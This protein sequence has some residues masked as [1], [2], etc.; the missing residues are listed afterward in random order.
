VLKGYFNHLSLSLHLKSSKQSFFMLRK[1]LFLLVVSLLTTSA[2]LAQVTTSSISGVVKDQAGQNLAGA[3]ITAVHQPSGTRYTTITQSGG[4]FTIANMRTGGP[5]Q[6]TITYVGMRTQTLNDIYLQLGEATVING[7]LESTEGTLQNVVVTGARRNNVLNANRTGAVTNIG[8]RE[9]NRL[10][11]IS[12]SINDFT[13]ITPQANG[14]AIGGGNNRQN[15]ITVDGSDFNN[16]FGIGGNLPAGGNPISLDAVEEISVSIAPYDVRQANF[17][18]SSINTVTRSGTNQ[19][20]GSVY[21]FFRNE[22]QRGNTVKGQDF[23]LQRENYSQWG[24]RVGGPII[25]NKLF[26][27]LNYETEKRTSPGQQRFAATATTGTGSY[28][29]A[30][31]IARPTATEL[32][33]IRDY[34]LKTYNYETGPYQGY[35]FVSD[36]VKMLARI[37]WNI[38]DKHRLTARYNQ[39]EGKTPLFMSGSSGSTGFNF[40][41]GFGRTDINALHFSNS[42][43]FQEN[44]FYSGQ[45][46]LNSRFTNR[47]SNI[48]RLSLNNQFEP[49]SSNSS[50]FPFVDI[51][52]DGQPFTSFGYEPFS[53]GNLRDV[54]IFT[55]TN[56]LTFITGK[57]NFLFGAQFDLSTTR[58][59]FQPLGASYYRFNSFADFQNGALPNDFAITYSLNPDFSQAFPT[60]KFAQY[61][62]YAQDEITF[63]RKFRLTVGLRADLNTYPDVAEVKTNPLVAGLTF[64]NGA[65]INTGEL[66]K[67][68]VML[69]PRVGFNYDPNGDRSLQIRGGTGIFTG[70]VP[71]VWIVGQSGN[72]GMLQVTQSFNGTANTTGFVFNQD[73]LFHVRRLNPNGPPAAGTVIP[74]TITAFDPNFTLPQTWKSSL[75]LDRR[76]PG[77]FI[78]TIDLI[79]NRDINV[80]YSKNVNL[81][82]PSPLNVAGYPD[83]RLIYPSTDQTRYINPITAQG[84]PGAG[85][86]SQFNAIVSGNENRGFYFSTTVQLQKQFSGG[87]FASLAYT[88]SIAENLYDGNG[89]QPFNTWSLIQTVNGANTPEL[90]FADYVVPHRVVGTFSYRK[91]FLKH[92]GTMISVFYSGQ[93]QGRFSYVYGADLNRDRQT[94]DLM[95]IPRDASEI[96]FVD[97]GT[98]GAAGYVS[99]ADQSRQFFEYIEQ[100]DYLRKRKGQYAERNGAL[101]PW[102]NQFDVKFTQDLFT[103]FLGSRNTLQFSV[104]IFNFTNL[105]NSEW[106]V[107]QTTNAA[108]LLDVANATGGNAYTPGGTIRPTFRLALDRGQPVKQTFRDNLNNSS[109]YFMQFG[110]R[111]IFG[112]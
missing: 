100:D 74:S 108:S 44:N 72:S 68:K 16:T 83:N 41:S 90:S 51:M 52:K 97:R 54:D 49:R 15:F 46:E 48:L 2:L 110:L 66:P 32:D 4:Q 6:I 56:N 31:N 58:N 101:L 20:N 38:S 59:G 10:P 3:S 104:D 92:L 42:N 81:V 98:P 33:A 37:D 70:R 17:V 105:L 1:L 12:R 107:T 82:N 43:Y 103:N 11:T 53:Y 94:N 96:T 106:G 87:L 35:D 7:N 27:F 102:R 86:N 5:Y 26:F 50:V 23:L 14:Q 36:Q 13:R 99:A 88:N 111:Y 22:N 76:L 24:V 71:F 89:D 45:L 95:Y 60:F 9:I 109:T 30:P 8:T 39:V 79:Y 80:L 28:G 61:A 84:R 62:A 77:G 29:S 21:T 91:E 73:P 40:S 65:K 57:H 55:A 85:A 93:H 18:G 67:P 112:N 78:A 63:S 75:G 64:A 47:L 19:I 69:S 25:K 34:L